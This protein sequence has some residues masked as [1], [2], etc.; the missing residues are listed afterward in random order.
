MGRSARLAMFFNFFVVFFAALI[1]SCTAG[2]DL[3]EDCRKIKP[4][5]RM[6]FDI[7]WDATK[8]LCSFSCAAKNNMPCMGVPDYVNLQF[9]N[10]GI[11]GERSMC[12]KPMLP[13]EMQPNL[14]TQWC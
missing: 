13:S 3:E 14:V 2:T 10:A 5:P 8:S 6:V 9:K 12:N 4:D 1:N 7:H 11:G